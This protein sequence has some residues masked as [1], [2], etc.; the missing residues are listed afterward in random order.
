MVGEFAANPGKTE[1]YINLPD[2]MML[3]RP[4]VG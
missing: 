3:G 4:P 2:R 1:L